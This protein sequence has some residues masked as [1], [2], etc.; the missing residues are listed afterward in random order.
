[1]HLA[2]LAFAQEP[3]GK[4]T[5]LSVSQ[6]SSGVQLNWTAPAGEVD[7]YGVLRRRPYKGESELMTLVADTD[8]IST[9]Y[10]DTTATEDG[11]RY[12]YRVKALLNGVKS[13]W[14][15]YDKLDVVAPTVE[16]PPATNTPVPPT[17][18]PVPP[19]N[20]PGKPTNLSVSQVSSGVQLN[21]TAPAGEV[22]GYEI[23][24]RRPYH[25]E[26]ELMTLVANT[27]NTSTTYTDSTAAEDG[28]RYTYWVKAILNGVKS[29]VSNYD[30]VDVVAP[31]VEAPPATNTAL[32]VTNTPVPAT[33]TA[34]P[35]TNTPVPVTNTPAPATNTSVP[36]FEGVA[37]FVSL[38]RDQVAQQQQQATP[39]CH[40]TYE[41]TV[42]PTSDR[43]SRIAERFAERPIVKA[44]HTN[45]VDSDE[46]YLGQT[47]QDIANPASTQ[48]VDGC[49]IKFASPVPSSKTMNGPDNCW[50]VPTLL[51]KFNPDCDII[52]IGWL[53]Y[54]ILMPA[55]DSDRE[56]RS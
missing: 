56:R 25:S 7:G 18:T 3:L 49:T 45:C 39:T 4:P 22:D 54:D 46:L 24:R 32:P 34:L 12:T 30:K 37:I 43:P 5:N 16:A 23:L 36:Q 35:V 27:G 6:V 8:N 44:V 33:N 9:T 28:V 10:T 13:D 52:P 1:M 19:T 14:S 17:N 42:F 29:S 53:D 11:V 40:F 2:G 31:T 48:T 15:N 21:W 55:R 50:S 38:D 51:T 47:D 41:V 26:S 20:T